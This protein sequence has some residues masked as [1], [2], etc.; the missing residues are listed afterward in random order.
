MGRVSTGLP[1]SVPLRSGPDARLRYATDADRVAL[2][3]L[4]DETVSACGGYPLRPPVPQ[5]E[6]D[7]YWIEGKTAVVAAELDDVIVGSYYL[8]PNHPGLAGH[9]ANAGYL[10]APGYQGRGLGR[11]LVEHSLASAR[12]HG[13]RAMQFNLVFASNPARTMYEALGFEVVGRLPD[14]VEG[15]DALIYWRSL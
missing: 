2:R 5:A 1:V 9:I 12:A 11:A 14:A 6:F 3:A 7:A 13:F 4:F 8:K 15:E 10:V